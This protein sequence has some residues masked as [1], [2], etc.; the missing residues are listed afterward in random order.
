MNGCSNLRHQS[1]REFPL[2]GGGNAITDDISTA[3]IYGGSTPFSSSSQKLVLPANH[4]FK[5][6]RSKR[7]IEVIVVGNVPIEYLEAL[8]DSLARVRQL[9]LYAYE[10]NFFQQICEICPDLR[11]LTLERMDQRKFN[12]R[13]CDD[14]ANFWIWSADYI[15]IN[16]S[17]ALWK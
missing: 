13:E 10:G 16:V 5:V 8:R 15:G 4:V 2:V 17:T 11:D 6:L 1:K 7:I 3:I 9:S 12:L 14:L